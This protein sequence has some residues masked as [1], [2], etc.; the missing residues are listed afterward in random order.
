MRLVTFTHQGSTRPGVVDG[1]DVVDLG[2][3]A[4]DMVSL[5]GLGPEGTHSIAAA[6]RER[7]PAALLADVRLEAPVRPGKFLAIGL[8]SRDHR[9]EITPGK[10]L[11]N[12]HLV[13]LGIGS[14]LAHPVTRYP[15]VFTKAPS[16]ITGPYDEIWSPRGEPTADY[17]GEL[18]I[19][20]GRRCRHLEA[21][22]VPEAIA[23]FTITND[24]SVRGW[25]LDS[26]MGPILAKGYATH[27]PLGPWITTSDERPDGDFLLRTYVNGEL[28]Q[29]GRSGALIA[30]PLELV[31]V[32]SRF[33]TL[34][35]G[36]VIACGT[37]AG[38]GLFDRRWLAPGDVVR[39]EVD[40]IGH[41]ENTVVDEP[42]GQVGF[43]DWPALRGA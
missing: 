18:C 35:P 39:V 30:P 8:N 21:E 26:P 40:G 25:Q 27:G 6:R 12:M 16:S 17:E 4:P 20:I 19:V 33:F 9:N 24:V 7:A 2:H 36:D 11:R 41:I 3:L 22:Q 13:R 29:E 31:R 28:R 37:F 14:K 1:E 5:L 10:L 42:R 15:I 43:L 34:E 38:V 23:G 32:M